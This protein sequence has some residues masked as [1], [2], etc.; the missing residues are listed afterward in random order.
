MG[1]QLKRFNKKNGLKQCLIL[2]YAPVLDG[3]L[4][5]LRVDTFTNKQFYTLLYQ[6]IYAINILQKNG[7]MHRDVHSGNIMYQLISPGKYQW[8][9]IDY[10]TIHH[11]SFI[12]NARDREWNN[13]PPDI[14]MFLWST[15]D[16]KFADYLLNKKLP[17][18]KFPKF[19]KYIKN[20]AAYNEIKSF[21]PKT[22]NKIVLDE[23]ISLVTAINHY[24]VYM[25]AIG[26][27]AFGGSDK[28][29]IHEKYKKYHT[30]QKYSEILLYIIKNCTSANF[31]AVLRHIKN[32]L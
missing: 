32:E 17:F 4:R 15:F 20:S 18:T 29:A 10:G 11:K 21:L 13:N 3:T 1:D 24:D 22:S 19:I 28:I 30:T 26:L 7:Y 23:C 16:N 12:E 9:I 31:D 5:S 27:D 6:V 14:L 8:Y 2:S 25:D